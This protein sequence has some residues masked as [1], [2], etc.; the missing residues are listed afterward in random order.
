MFGEVRGYTGGDSDNEK[1]NNDNDANNPYNPPPMQAFPDT[2]SGS[3]T[4]TNFYPTYQRLPAT[5][6]TQSVFNL[7]SVQNV[8]GVPAMPHVPIGPTGALPS[9]FQYS[10]LPYGQDNQVR[11]AKEIVIT[12]QTSMD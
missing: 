10:G 2:P 4:Q 9:R 8:P 6:P 1:D 12:I 5:Q 7:P 11:R 3:D